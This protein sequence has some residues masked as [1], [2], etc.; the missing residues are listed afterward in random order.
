MQQHPSPL[1]Q[2]PQIRFRRI[3]VFIAALLAGLPL[4]AAS[5]FSLLAA[6]AGLL[7]AAE[8]VKELTKTA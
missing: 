8:I 3:A 7:L 2:V 1:G 4:A 5:L 6:A